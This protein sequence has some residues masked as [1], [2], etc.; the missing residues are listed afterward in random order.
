MASATQE[1]LHFD[2]DAPQSA[3]PAKD[4]AAAKQQ[5]DTTPDPYIY[6]SNLPVEA[7]EGIIWQAIEDEG[8][9]VVSMACCKS[10]GH[11]SQ[12]VLQGLGLQHLI[13]GRELTSTCVKTGMEIYWRVCRQ[14]TVLHMHQQQL[15]IFGHQGHI[16]RPC[17]AALIHNQHAMLVTSDSVSQQQN[18][19]LMCTQ[20]PAEHVRCLT[21]H[22]VVLWPPCVQASIHLLQKGS[23]ARRRNAG[24]AE[25][26]LASAADAQRSCELLDGKL[27]HVGADTAQG[28]PMIGRRGKFES[29]QFGY[30]GKQQQDTDGSDADN[31]DSQAGL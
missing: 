23:S 9:S 27:L 3:S 31:A 6:L 26:K 13:R 14:H 21:L 29:C 25:V 12:V 5:A 15:T 17:D 19:V 11:V 7:S 16:T 22:H 4:G 1:R 2:S 18:Q 10:S 24:L 30:N 8:I 20:Y 28:R